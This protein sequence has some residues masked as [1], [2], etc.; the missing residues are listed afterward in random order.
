MTPSPWHHFDISMDEW[1]DYLAWVARESTLPE[2]RR[3]KLAQAG[4]V[5]S[6]LGSPQTRRR[7]CC[8]RPRISMGR[9][10]GASGR[11]PSG[12]GREIRPRRAVGARTA[13]RPRCSRLRLDDPRGGC[14]RPHPS[15]R[16]HEQPVGCLDQ[17]YLPVLGI[18]GQ[19]HHHAL[20]QQLLRLSIR[21]VGGNPLH[22]SLLSGSLIF[23]EGGGAVD[24]GPV[25]DELVDGHQDVRR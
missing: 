8:A 10:T 2:E 22:R 12:R 24:V 18:G 5:D 14:V 9:E 21:G 20:Q 7:C 23:G 13:H 3:D 6:E 4:L 25:L 16:S 19:F 17:G 11:A 15:L 1:N